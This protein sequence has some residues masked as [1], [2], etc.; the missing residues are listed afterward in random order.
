MKERKIFVGA[1]LAVIVVSLVTITTSTEGGTLLQHVYA[2]NNGDDD[3]DEESNT[4][5]ETEEEKE[6]VISGVF[7][8]C[9]MSDAPQGAALEQTTRDPNEVPIILA[10]PT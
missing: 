1:V 3:G 9:V 2:T 7:N 4:E 6:C 8:T 10:L 5:I